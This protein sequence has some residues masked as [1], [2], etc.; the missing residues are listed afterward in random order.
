MNFYCS[1]IWERGSYG[2]LSFPSWLTTVWSQ[3][4]FAPRFIVSLTHLLAC[5]C[6][7]PAGFNLGNLLHL[8]I[9]SL[10]LAVLNFSLA[11]SAAIQFS[12]NNSC[13]LSSEYG[14]AC[15]LASLIM[16]R[17]LVASLLWRRS[18]LAFHLFS[19]RSCLLLLRRSLNIF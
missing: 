1:R 18:S 6:S 16:L 12:F 8:I 5:C 2:C 7:D 14:L 10:F 19:F 9:L 4:M 3:C 13:F 15:L 11:C 17:L